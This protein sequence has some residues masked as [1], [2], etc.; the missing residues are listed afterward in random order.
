[1]NNKQ[2]AEMA[3]QANL[4]GKVLKIKGKKYWLEDAPPPDVE[5]MTG[6]AEAEKDIEAERLIKAEREAYMLGNTKR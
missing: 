4:Q 2:Y 1:M 5:I 6:I 3:H